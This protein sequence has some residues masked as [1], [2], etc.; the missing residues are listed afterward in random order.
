MWD[1]MK[2]Y[3]DWVG[4]GGIC[5]RVNIYRNGQRDPKNVVNGVWQVEGLSKTH[6]QWVS[7][8]DQT[9]VHVLN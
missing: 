2:I 1:G 9:V 4:I 8:A 7:L 3:E 5:E 6:F